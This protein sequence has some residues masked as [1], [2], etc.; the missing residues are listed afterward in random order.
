[1]VKF[2]TWNSVP[3]S[4]SKRPAH[5]AGRLPGKGEGHN[6]L[7]LQPEMEQ[8]RHPMGQGAGLAGAGAGLHQQRTAGV[9]HGRN[10]GRI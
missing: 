10:L 5:L 8:M 2:A 6:L 7:R 1:M 3:K 4:C 9:E